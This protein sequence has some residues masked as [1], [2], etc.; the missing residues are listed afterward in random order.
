[1]KSLQEPNDNNI[2]FETRRRG[3]H[4]D[5]DLLLIT[6]IDVKEFLLIFRH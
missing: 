5:R 1:M 2:H 4:K 3:T 6:L